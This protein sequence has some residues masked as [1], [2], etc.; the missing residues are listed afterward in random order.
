MFCSFSCNFWQYYGALHSLFTVFYLIQNELCI[1][2]IFAKQRVTKTF[3]PL[4]ETL[5]RLYR[6]TAAAVLSRAPVIGISCA[7]VWSCPIWARLVH[8]LDT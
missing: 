6:G 7:R 2:D 5:G 3:I 8:E 4:A 1:Q